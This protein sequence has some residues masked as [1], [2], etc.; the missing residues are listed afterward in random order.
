[1]RYHNYRN[2][3]IVQAKGSITVTGQGSSAQNGTEEIGSQSQALTASPSGW[4]IISDTQDFAERR[5]VKNLSDEPDGW[6]PPREEFTEYLRPE[7]Y[8]SAER[9]Q[10][11]LTVSFDAGGTFSRYGVMR[12]SY[13]VAWGPHVAKGTGSP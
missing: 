9:G 11:P 4:G 10:A 5:K 8:A 2:E 6:S 3:M 12:Y 7:L 1:M 13:D